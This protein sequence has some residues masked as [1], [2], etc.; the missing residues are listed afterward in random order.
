MIVS[1]K[2]QAD[3]DADPHKQAFLEQYPYAFF[4][5]TLKYPRQFEVIR[6]WVERKPKITVLTGWKRTGKTQVAVYLMSCWFMSQLDK[7][8]PGA[9]AMGI[10]ESLKWKKPTGR[11]RIA[12]IGG[13]SMDHLKNVLIPLYKNVIPRSAIAHDMTVNDKSITGHD[14]TKFLARTYDQDLETWKSG[15]AELVHLDEEPP[16]GVM[17]ECLDRTR[18]TEGKILITVA[19]DDAD[20]SWLPDACQ[21]PMKYFGTDSFLH[22]KM[23]IEDV[24]EEIYPETEK[25]NT[26][27]KYDGTPFENAV[28]KGDFAY[29]SGRW[30]KEFDPKIHVIPP[31]KIPD[32]W[33]RWRFM[34]SGY[35]SQTA[36]AWVAL[37]PDGNIFVYREYYQAGKVIQQRCM[38]IIGMSGNKR[39][40]DG[41]FWIEQEIGE[42]YIGT[43]IDHHVF[44]TD[45]VTG[46]GAEQNWIQ[47]GLLIQP[48]TTLQQEPRREIVNK[49]LCVDP[50]RKHFITHQQ[51]APRIYIFDSCPNLIWEAQKK[52]VKRERTDKH[53][54]SEKKILNRDDHLMDCVEYACA[55]L[56]NW[57]G[58]RASDFFQV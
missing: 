14:G 44:K 42:K 23:G 48:S 39:Q 1:K 33:L 46:D 27:R 40:K 57:A 22:L 43:Y 45:E 58:L 28:R 34:D 26:Y 11:D 10:K 32:H 50:R 5:A 18:T 13:K 52:A 20:V 54:V 24:P 36:C 30:W 51:G 12:W 8:W 3:L 35:S 55:E 47:E 41:D 15:T 4:G 29:I 7:S 25:Q 17:N 2:L 37:H 49:W 6:Q 31:F 53:G 16:I 19:I 21:N 38:D 56:E 9:K